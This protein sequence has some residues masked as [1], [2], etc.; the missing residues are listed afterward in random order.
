MSESE[1]E[2][3]SIKD[4]RPYTG[5]IKCRKSMNN[6]SVDSHSIN[7]TNTKNPTDFVQHATRNKQQSTIPKQKLTFKVP[8]KS[9]K[10]VRKDRERTKKGK[11]TSSSSLIFANKR[12]DHGSSSNGRKEKFMDTNINKVKK[13]KSF[14]SVNGEVEYRKYDNGLKFLC[15]EER[16]IKH[17]SV[18]INTK[19]DS[20]DVKAAKKSQVETKP[21]F[22]HN[23]KSQSHHPSHPTRTS[24]TSNID[25]TRSKQSAYPADSD[26]NSV[27]A[28]KFINTFPLKNFNHFLATSAGEVVKPTPR[29]NRNIPMEDAIIP[30]N[31]NRNNKLECEMEASQNG[32]ETSSSLAICSATTPRQCDDCKNTT[33]EGGWLFEC[34]NIWSKEGKRADV[35]VKKDSHNTA[36]LPHVIKPQLSPTHVLTPPFSAHRGKY[37]GGSRALTYQ[38]DVPYQTRTDI[39]KKFVSV[40][41]SEVHGPKRTMR[42]VKKGSFI[43]T[44]SS[45]PAQ[46]R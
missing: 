26:F 23:T 9:E 12:C 11:H 44:G 41:R 4:P 39:N 21:L 19:S 27:H 36:Y 22:D 15:S 37:Q 32:L 24:I 7:L 40:Y 2:Y 5:N 10:F 18:E 42:T 43:F 16:L 17:K 20:C 38:L 28:F 1:E 33:V 35:L 45:F 25:R 31:E 30:E 13:S 8:F 46:Y 3:F 29:G 6:S 34:R 14:S